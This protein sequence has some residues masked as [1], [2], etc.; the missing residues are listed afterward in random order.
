MASMKQSRVFYDR[1]GY[2]P[3]F[4]ILNEDQARDL[5]TKFNSMEEEIGLYSYIGLPDVVQLSVVSISHY[6]YILFVVMPPLREHADIIF[7]WN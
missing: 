5:R 4:D 6:E 7:I 2:L 3:A 1:N